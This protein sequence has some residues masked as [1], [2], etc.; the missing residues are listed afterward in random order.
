MKPDHLETFE[1]SIKMNR[2][3]DLIFPKSV[4]THQ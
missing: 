4:S 3:Q 1:F 2:S